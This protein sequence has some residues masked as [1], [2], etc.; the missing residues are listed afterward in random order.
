MIAGLSESR[1]LYRLVVR[2]SGLPVRRNGT[3]TLE[4]EWPI[5]KRIDPDVNIRQQAERALRIP[6]A[7]QEEQTIRLPVLSTTNR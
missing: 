4:G 2:H 3:F 6:L 1:Q 7:W 5:V